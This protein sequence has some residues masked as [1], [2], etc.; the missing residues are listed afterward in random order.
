MAFGPGRLGSVQGVGLP[1]P[2]TAA[3]ATSNRVAGIESLTRTLQS[4]R[5]L[6][7]S[8]MGWASTELL[9][10]DQ[11]QGRP[12]IGLR[13]QR[14]LGHCGRFQESQFGVPT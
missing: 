10:G 6:L 2:R 8:T 12:Y 14:V 13:D 1:C 5:R 11:S 4:P 9:I 7:G 3:L